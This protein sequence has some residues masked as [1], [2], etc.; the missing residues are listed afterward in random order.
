MLPDASL[1]K[2]GGAPVR[3]GPVAPRATPPPPPGA[4]DATARAPR[5]ALLHAEKV[6]TAAR[7]AFASHAR[8]T[9]ARD[10]GEGPPDAHEPANGGRRRGPTSRELSGEMGGDTVRA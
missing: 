3:P 8:G 10:G 6:V 9:A 7:L 2:A 4:P 5:E 1:P